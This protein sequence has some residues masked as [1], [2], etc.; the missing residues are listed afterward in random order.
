MFSRF[1][2]VLIGVIVA[3]ALWGVTCAQVMFYYKTFPRDRKL[4]KSLVAA[5]WISDTL[6]QILISHTVYV[7]LVTFYGDFNAIGKIVWS[8]VVEVLVNSALVLG[9]LGKWIVFDASMAINVFGVASDLFLSITLC[10]LLHRSRSGVKRTDTMINVLILF[11]MNTG[12]LT[13]LCAVASLVSILAAPT[14]FIY[15]AFFFNIGRMYSNTLLVVLNARDS[16]RKI[17]VHPEAV[18]LSALQTTD[19]GKAAQVR[20]HHLLL[21]YF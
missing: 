16:I 5:V 15:I 6:H 12:L 7:Y 14:T 4:I 13:S 8:I 10:F 11:T 20:L 9:E 2:A 19:T 17:G 1:G 3:A 18:V 21:S